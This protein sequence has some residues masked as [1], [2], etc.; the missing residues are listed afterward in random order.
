MWGASTASYQIEGA[1]NEDGRGRSIWDTFSH[2]PGRVKNGD[3]GDTACDHYHRYAED[4]ALMRDLGL[5]AYRFSTSWS[6]LLPEGRGR[7][8]P[9]GGDFYDRLIDTLLGAGITPWLCLYHWDLPQALQDKGGWQNRDI[10]HWF[11][12]YAAHVAERYGDRVE[13]FIMFNE[14]HITALLGHLLGL[15]APGVKSKDA[16]AAAIH[17]QNLAQGSALKMLRET[18]ERW[19]LGTVFNLQPVHPATDSE[20]DARAAEFFDAWSNRAFLDPLFRGRY[21]E[22]VQGVLEPHIQGGDLDLIEQPVDFLGL[23]LYTRTRVRADKDTVLGVTQAPPSP[24]ATLT[25][26]GWEVYPDALYEQLM[27]LAQH[28]DN[29]TVFVTENGAAFPDVPT[30]DGSVEDDDRV[31]FFAQYLE[32]LHRALS[33]GANVRGYFAWSLLDNFEWAEGY[34]K[35]FGLIYV[36][37]ATQRRTPKRS[38]EWFQELIRTHRIPSL[39]E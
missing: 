24:D 32:A 30:P 15:H 29:P 12:D 17:H 28:Y 18:S 22:G 37:Y 13:H 4:V 34:T 35:R 8:N 31:A 25:D 27:D 6:R 1:V 16:Y 19:K 26:M 36:D 14:P 39:E 9:K 21:P 38:F 7:P 3:T 20:E 2:T 33:E 23:N 5:D 11:T 10:A